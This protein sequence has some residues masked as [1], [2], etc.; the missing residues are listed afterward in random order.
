M[1]LKA[2]LHIHTAEDQIDGYIIKYNIYQLIDKASQLGF[3]VLA[4]TC[5]RK[6]VYRKEYGDY[7]KDKGILLISGIELS[8]SK[9]MFWRNDLIVLN[10]DKNIEQVKTFK[11]L[12]DYKKRHPEIFIIA[13]HPNFGQRQSMGIKKLIKYIDLFDAIEHCWFYSSKINFNRRVEKIAKNFFKP[14]IATA[15]AHVLTYFNTDYAIIDAEELT[16]QSIFTAIKQNK[17]I[18]ITK[19]KKLLELILYIIIN[20]FKAFLFLPLRWWHNRKLDN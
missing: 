8:M 19:P 17:F 18:N 1:K 11:Q 3:K 13:A 6:F 15:D 5:H 9:F 12:A 14:F 20:E 7:A 10:C 2:S 4:V 16:P